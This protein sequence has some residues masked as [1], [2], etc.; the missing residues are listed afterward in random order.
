MDMIPAPNQPKPVEDH[1]IPLIPSYGA[2]EPSVSVPSHTY[3]SEFTFT[4]I[5]LISS[6]DVQITTAMMVGFTTSIITLALVMF[7]ANRAKNNKF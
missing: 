7:W 1:V 3:I 6:I 4:M 5:P 2:I